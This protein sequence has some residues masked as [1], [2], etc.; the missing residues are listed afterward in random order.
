MKPL[1]LAR[2]AHAEAGPC[3]HG[4]KNASSVGSSHT[5]PELAMAP[6]YVKPGTWPA[7]RPTTP[8]SEGPNP[9]TPGVIVWHD[10]RNQAGAEDPGLSLCSARRA[11]RVDD[12]L[13]AGCVLHGDNIAPGVCADSA[14][15]F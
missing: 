3:A 12:D 13:A 1:E 10:A 7:G 6:L 14:L 8:A 4:E 5:R 15:G 2:I 9:F 11:A